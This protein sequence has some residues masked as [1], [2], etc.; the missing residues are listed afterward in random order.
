MKSLFITSNRIGDC[1]LSTGILNH[2]LEVN[3][4]HHFTVVCGP[5]AA[6]LFFATP[7]VDRVIAM[8]K[9]P[10]GRHWLTLWRQVVTTRW[11]LVVDLRVSLLTW[12]LL[13]RRRTVVRSQADG[14]HRVEALG[15]VVCP[16]D[17]PPAPKIYAGVEHRSKAAELVPAGGPVLAVAPTANWGGKVWPAERFVAAIAALTGPGGILAGARVAVFG[18]PSERAMA[19]PVL[20]GVSPDRLIDLVGRLDLLTAYACLER[21]DFFIGNDSALM[22]MA[23]ASGIPTLGL[24]G[25]S[26]EEIYSPWGENALAIRTDLSFSQIKALPGYDYRRHDSHMTTLSVE[27]VLAAAERLWRERKAA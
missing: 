7:R 14:R 15:H 11:E 22:H 27:K 8:T 3:P 19:Q 1:V 16:A 6:P 17:P 24:F 4:D 12:V 2:L 23:A 25:P 13:A 18:A 26:R 20:A 5:G 21:S 10:R 9:A